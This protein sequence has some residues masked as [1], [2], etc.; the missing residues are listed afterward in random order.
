ME[1]M[2]KGEQCESIKESKILNK[3]R[4]EWKTKM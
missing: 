4:A 1:I 3:M 2:T